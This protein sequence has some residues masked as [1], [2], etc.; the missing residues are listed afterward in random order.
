MSER[1]WIS[2]ELTTSLEE[3]LL[4]HRLH[5]VH[6]RSH[7][8]HRVHRGLHRVH[9]RSHRSHLDLA[10]RLAGRQG[11]P[12]LY[13]RLVTDTHCLKDALRLAGGPPAPPDGL[14]GGGAWADPSAAIE[15]ATTA[16]NF[17]LI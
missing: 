2:D 6:H 16:E 7:R 8:I 4:V 14:L 17:I 13:N 3:H 9:H 10:H 5:R 12:G 11:L 1:V 15:R